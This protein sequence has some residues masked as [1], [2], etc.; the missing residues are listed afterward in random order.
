ML[1]VTGKA[2]LDALE[3]S[4]CLYPALEGRFPQVSH[5]EFEFDPNKPAGSRILNVKVAKAPIDLDRV[6][7]LVTRGYMARGKDGYNSLLVK[8]EG[9]TAEEVVSEE[10][11][12]LIATIIRQYFLS[13]K[14]L[15]KWKMF[16]DA[17]GNH[18]DAIHE[19]LHQRHPVIHP[20]PPE[21]QI[22][23]AFRRAANSPKHFPEERNRHRPNH[24]DSMP[25]GRHTPSR[26]R[27][28][29]VETPL[30]ESEDEHS[31]VKPVHPVVTQRARE[32]VIMR[33]VMRKWWRLTGLPGHPALCDQ[34][35]EG[36]FMVNWT[37]VGQ[38]E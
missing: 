16:G 24:V 32:L 14:V 26:R 13:L 35:G 34:L 21:H 7:V 6:Y 15:R 4:V 31:E 36:E 9:G 1:K 25:S 30:D 5:I 28:E 23:E 22:V 33:K 27:L 29:G 37:K 19:R 2:I 8:S 20:Q 18:W 11:G 17:M 38:L 10:N 3:N 12:V